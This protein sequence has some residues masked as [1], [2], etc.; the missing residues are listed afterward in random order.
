M[1]TTPRDDRW[2]PVLLAAIGFLFSAYLEYLHVL[3]WL[4]PSVSSVC[5]VAKAADCNAVALSRFSTFAGVP[6]PLWGAAGFLA[7]LVAAIRRS[8]WL[9]PL[10][11]VAALAS[12]GLLVVEV[13]AIGSVC[14]FCEVVHVVSWVL[15]FVA[16]LRR[17][18]FVTPYVDTQLLTYGMAPALGLIVAA[19]IAIPPYW[20]IPTWRS[21][22]PFAQGVTA[23]GHP[24]LGSPAP[25]LTVEE[26]ID[27]ACPHCKVAS[28]RMLR[29]LAKQGS[30]V[31]VVR[32]N[33]PRM[34]CS[35]SAP[36]SC[37]PLRVALCAAKQDR[38]WQMDRWLFAYAGKGRVDVEAAAREVGVDLAALKACV[39]A[40]ETYQ[41]ADN[42]GRAA[43]KAR[44][45]ETPGY[46]IDG[47]KVKTEDVAARLKAAR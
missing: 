7:M 6:L 25:S 17:R 24:W 30:K 9:L 37:M 39:V 3:A 41:A 5:T 44:V 8:R 11:L 28:E 33:N 13:V 27:Y 26:W 40:P 46:T 1:G 29:A 35:V 21:D 20:R 34:S 45:I 32:R 19:A 43:R 2:L 36:S 38:F 22:V 4:D 42:E 14:L 47:K 15:L 12:V 16:W 10:A 23:E 18:Q 31:R